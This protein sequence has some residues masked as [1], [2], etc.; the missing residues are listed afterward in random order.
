MESPNSKV[1]VV[2][3]I[4]PPY[5]VELFRNFLISYKKY[6]PGFEHN[7]V[8]LFNGATGLDDTEPF[9][10]ISRQFN[11]S[12]DSIS[13][14]SSLDLEAYFW[15]AKQFN[16][17]Y[18]LFLNSFCVILDDNW[19]LK[20]IKHMNDARVGIVSPSGSYQSFYNTVF[21]NNSWKWNN[22]Q[23]LKE[24]Y[25]KYKLL[26]KAVLYWRFLF[27]PFPNPHIRT[28]AFLIRRELFLSLKRKKIRNKF[29]A[30]RL[31]SCYNSINR[32]IIKKGYDVLIVDKGGR[33]Y[34]I[35]EW[36]STKIFWKGKQED[37]LISDKQ[38]E[39]YLSSNEKTKNELSYLAWGK[40]NKIE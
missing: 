28:N 33:A 29:M 6:S 31:E 16:S 27:P 37:L 34:K 11:L 40:S 23:S 19:L 22:H 8:L 14:Q 35:K 5:G 12:C 32:Q 1:S 10:E 39:Y 15:V 30:Y 17:T 9:R 2:Y 7:L 26:I 21:F 18:F 36:N 25:L 20:L 3:L 4:W 38:T 24:N 13:K